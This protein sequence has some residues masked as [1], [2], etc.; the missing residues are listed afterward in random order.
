[1]EKWLSRTG[2]MEPPSPQ[3]ATLIKDHF[4]AS[5]IFNEMMS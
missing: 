2:F 4:S 1:M 5:Q 3:A